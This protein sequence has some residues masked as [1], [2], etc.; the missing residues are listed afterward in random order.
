[1]IT[2]AKIRAVVE[3]DTTQAKANLRG[4]GR[5][6]DNTASTTRRG[7]GGIRDALNGLPGPLGNLSALLTGAGFATAAIGAGKLA[8]ELDNQRQMAE[9]VRKELEAYAGG[10]REAEAAT[11]ALL[12]ATEGGISK[13]DAMRGASQLLGMGLVKNADEAYTMSRMAVMLGD[14]MLS[15]TDRMASWN[16]MLANQSI[17]RLDTFGISSGRVRQ[18]I[19]EL[20]TANQNLSRE[21]AFVSAVL[22]I[23]AGKLADVEAA[24]VKAATSMDTF[25]A[26]LRNLKQAMA[27]QIDA[28]GF[29]T[30]LNQIPV[31]LERIIT[32][33]TAAFDAMQAAALREA[34]AFDKVLEAERNLER[35]RTSWQFALTRQAS[36]AYYQDLL[37][38]AEATLELAAAESDHA[39]K[40]YRVAMGLEVEGQAADMTKARL[41]GLAA[42]NRDAAA[43]TV[44]LHQATTT[45]TFTEPS[46][47]RWGL[48]TDYARKLAGATTSKQD[49][50]RALEDWK[51]RVG[52]VN[53]DVA[54]KAG[55]SY[56]DAMTD[57]GKEA[58]NRISGFL[59]EGMRFSI[60][61]DDMTSNP[62][63]PG[64]NGP[65]E[66]I[67]RLQA[68][69]KDGSWGDVAGLLGGDR[70][71]IAGTV[72]AFQMGNFTDDVVS[73]IDTA[74]LRQMLQD[75]LAAEA[76]QQA[77]AGQLGGDASI[78]KSLL[79]IDTAG[80][81]IVLSQPE[82]AALAKSLAT[83]VSSG[84]KESTLGVDVIAAMI[85]SM[86]T[87]LAADGGKQ[88]EDKGAAAFDK[89]GGGF[90]K[91]AKESP[92][93]YQAV[94]AMVDSY[95]AK[96]L[97]Q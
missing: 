35:A 77:L 7:I 12:R 41:L 17:E 9:N 20:M 61:L 59:Q 21:Q 16:A 48:Y 94:G 26:S 51:R 24:G 69:L 91:R 60:G 5:E 25:S 97:E 31:G 30:W 73:M 39:D 15:A 92:I 64:Q 67:Y 65:F 86:D 82:S 50:A 45:G 23:G 37:N 79:G 49:A 74:G 19:D 29:M 22:E 32:G 66:Q 81:G 68:W 6:V 72:K 88:L 56:L 44:A 40:L 34:A 42:A 96:E 3:A 58:A 85:G 62:L 14:K 84:L 47:T 80:Q 43:A 83:G 4:F 87:E 8:M 38:Q 27:D 70:E 95:I 2:A 75:K 28:S 13:L 93:F 76:S 71:R 46:K 33:Q 18:R 1:M 55:K 10:A 11:N 63:S 89:V 78:L 52:L 90:V 36:I 53:D 54:T 57:A